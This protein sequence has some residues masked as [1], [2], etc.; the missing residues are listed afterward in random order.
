MLAVSDN[1]CGM[2]EEVRKHIFEPFFT[3]K[4]EEGGTGLGLATVYGIVKQ[5]GGN[6]WFYSEPG[7]GTT[8]KIYLPVTG[9]DVAEEA[10]VEKRDLADLCGTETILLVEDNEQ[11]R[12]VSHAILEQHGYSILLAE[13]GS[14]ALQVLE[15]HEGPVHLLLTDVIMPGMNGRELFAKVSG[16]YPDVR[17][18]YMSG[19]TDNVIAHHGV[20]EEEIQFI[21]KPLSIKALATKVRVVLEG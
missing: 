21:Q 12:D 8:F 7:I 15:D 3:T 10:T 9:E 11:V 6:V 1:G 2:D 20:L 17:V 13:R 16:L 14:E 18:L 19:Y 4:G 5:H